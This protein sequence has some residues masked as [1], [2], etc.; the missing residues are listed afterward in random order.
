MRRRSSTRGTRPVR[1]GQNSHGVRP[2][3]RPKSGQFGNVAFCNRARSL[4]ALLRDGIIHAYIRVNSTTCVCCP[5]PRQTVSCGS[6]FSAR[7]GTQ[8]LLE[9]RGDKTTRVPPEVRQRFGNATFRRRHGLSVRG[10]L[11]VDAVD[12]GFC[13]RLDDTGAAPSSWRAPRSLRDV[14]VERVL[15]HPCIGHRSF[16]PRCVSPPVTRALLGR[17]LPCTRLLEAV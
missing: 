5:H 7:Q 13:R 17:V 3:G 8:A 15:L 2:R 1:E 14:R 4:Y 10:S 11:I 16:L 6:R 9:T 12:G